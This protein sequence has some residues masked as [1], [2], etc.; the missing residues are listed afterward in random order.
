MSSQVRLS[1]SSP[2]LPSLDS[3]TVRLCRA[4]THDHSAGTCKHKAVC[5]K[6]KLYLG[7]IMQRQIACVLTVTFPTTFFGL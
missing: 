3:C 6:Q 2:G 5:Q 7:I 1:R 4:K